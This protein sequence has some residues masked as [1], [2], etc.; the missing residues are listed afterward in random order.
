MRKVL[1]LAAA[2]VLSAG[3]AAAQ[4]PASNGVNETGKSAVVLPA[5]TLPAAQPGVPAQ[6]APSFHLSRDEVR[7]QVRVAEQQR[8]TSDAAQV[9]SRNWWYLVAAIAVGVI[10]ALLILD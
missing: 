1:I 3:Q 6:P 5:A 9:G 7:E 8:A 4:Q 2:L 10:V